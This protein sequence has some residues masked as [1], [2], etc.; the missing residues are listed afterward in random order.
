MIRR[1]HGYCLCAALL[2]CVAYSQAPEPHKFE[3]A[4]VKPSTAD[5]PGPKMDLAPS[6]SVNVNI[7][8]WMLIQMAYRVKDYQ[9]AG[10]PKWLDKEFFRIV[11]KPPLGPV[12]A[13]Q[14]AQNALFEERMRYL[15][16]ERFHLVTH[17][18]TRN[19]PEYVL[20]V[21]KGGP[22]LKELAS[23]P[24]KFRLR[25]GKGFLT[26]GSGAKIAMLVSVLSNQL[27]APVV[28]G[29]SGLDKYYDLQ[30]KYPVEDDANAG[31]FAALQD[32]LGLKL[33]SRKGPV[34]VLVIDS[35]DR[36]AEN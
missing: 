3:V 2:A 23:D 22:K 25:F 20:V 11:A 16:E 36:P 34:E 21:A 18:E 14:S 28:D 6:G 7:T 35:M 10:A 13:G 26:T 32:Q 27:G 30:L 12:P 5:D 15:L 4:S 29:T 19:L 24:G 9:I 1:P 31:L 33:E 17:R 8:P